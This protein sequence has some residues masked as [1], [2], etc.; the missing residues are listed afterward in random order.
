[1]QSVDQR[2]IDGNDARVGMCIFDM[3]NLN[4]AV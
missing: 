3:S 2:D 1:M 4:L